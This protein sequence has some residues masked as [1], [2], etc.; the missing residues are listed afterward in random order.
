MKTILTITLLLIGMMGRGQEAKLDNWYHLTYPGNDT[1]NFVVYSYDSANNLKKVYYRSHYYIPTTVNYR[2]DTLISRSNMLGSDYYYYSDDDTVM[3]ISN[4]QGNT[5]TSYLRIDEYNEVIEY[6]GG[7]SWNWEDGNCMEEIRWGEDTSW[8]RE[9]Y[10][11]YINPWYEENKYLR[12]GAQTGTYSG[13][14]NLWS[15]HSFYGTDDVEFEVIESIGPYP[16]II[17]YNSNG[18]LLSTYYFEYKYVIPSVDYFDM[19]GRKIAKPN[20]GFYIERKNTDKGIIST[21][22]YMR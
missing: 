20:K 18:S 15:I 10:S 19:L 12:R 6:G 22:R 1:V 5:D 11:E 16:T 9:Y 7:Y 13:S 3:W 4:S 2:N 17:D 14:Y 21:K 8:Y